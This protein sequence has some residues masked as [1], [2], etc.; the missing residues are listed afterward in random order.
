MRRRGLR[1]V[2]SSPVQGGEVW[3]IEKKGEDARGKD[4]EVPSG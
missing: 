4:G 3:D 2:I 1:N